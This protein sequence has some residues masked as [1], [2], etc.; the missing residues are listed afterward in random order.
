MGNPDFTNS[1]VNVRYL[2]NS[3]MLI[4]GTIEKM[5]FSNLLNFN[6]LTDFCDDLIRIRIK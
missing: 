5:I 6:L 4:F 3:S 2:V 1:V